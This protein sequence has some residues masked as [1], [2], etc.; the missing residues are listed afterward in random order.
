MDGSRGKQ[1]QTATADYHPHGWTQ[2]HST[3]GP[4]WYTDLLVVSLSS[5][6]AIG[7]KTLVQ[8]PNIR[9]LVLNSNNAVGRM[10]DYLDKAVGLN[11]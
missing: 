1:L 3:L 5:I 4:A 10:L 8:N 7:H 9:D 6:D 11:R 2:P